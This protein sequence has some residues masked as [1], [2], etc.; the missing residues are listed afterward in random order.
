MIDTH[1]HL[2]DEKFADDVE[3]AQWM[4]AVV[5]GAVQLDWA[6]AHDLPDFHVG[7]H[8]RAWQGL[9]ES[10]WTY[11]TALPELPPLAADER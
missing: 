11:R 7:D 4:P 2:T 9:D 5:P 1:A 10:P 8:V 6:R 3:A